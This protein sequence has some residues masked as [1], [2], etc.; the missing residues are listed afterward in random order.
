MFWLTVPLGRPADADHSPRLLGRPEVKR[1]T[2]RSID[3]LQRKEGSSMMNPQDSGFHPEK[4]EAMP[5]ELPAQPAS[6]ALMASFLLTLNILTSFLDLSPDALIVVDSAGTIVL[7]NT[8][9]ETLFGYGRDEL[10]GQ[11]LEFILPERLRAAH[12][13]QRTHY[14]QA[15]RPR[16]MHTGLNL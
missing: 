9:L 3:T 14:M 7:V 13:A 1:E 16:P 6:T 4:Q 12:V 8:Q 15:A 5:G 2:I 11:M 10:I